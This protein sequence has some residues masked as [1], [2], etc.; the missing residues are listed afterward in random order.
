MSDNGGEQCLHTSRTHI[1]H[2][3]QT[4]RYP[5]AHCDYEMQPHIVGSN[6]KKKEIHFGV[7]NSRT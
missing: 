7:L 4:A 6:V 3:S 5:D 2:V 1:K